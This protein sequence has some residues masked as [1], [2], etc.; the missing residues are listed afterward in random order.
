M[1]I[2]ALHLINTPVLVPTSTDT[3]EDVYWFDSDN[4]E[5]VNEDNND[6]EEVNEDNDDDEEVNEDN[7]EPT[8]LITEGLG[9]DDYT[10]HEVDVVLVSAG[11]YG[12]SP[13]QRRYGNKKT[14]GRNKRNPIGK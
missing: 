12:K 9:N 6:D 4:D 10:P 8:P 5:E 14:K 13:N 3:I 11:G 1:Y 2:T 7:E